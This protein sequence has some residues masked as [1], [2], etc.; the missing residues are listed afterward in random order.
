MAAALAVALALG[1][2]A[3]QAV[4]SAYAGGVP[5]RAANAGFQPSAPYYATFFYPWFGNKTTNGTW[6]NSTWGDNGHTPPANWFSNYLP[7][8]EPRVFDPAHEL[9]SS[10]DDTT[11]A[12]QLSKLAEAKQEVAISSWWGQGHKTDTALKH[13]LWY[14]QQPENPYPNLRWALYYEK[15]GFGNPSVDEIASDLRYIVDNLASQSAFF[16]IDGKPVIFV[17]GS[18][19]DSPATADRWAEARKQAGVD[20]FLVLK[21][22][23]GYASAKSQ[24]DGWH[25]YAPAER[26]DSQSHRYFMVSPGFWKDG[27]PARLPRDVD[28]FTRVVKNMVAA[29]V[30][31]KLTETWNEWGEGTAVE[32]GTPVIQTMTG[33]AIRDP[34]GPPFGN[35]YVDVLSRSLPPLEQGTGAPLGAS[36]PDSYGQTRVPDLVPPYDRPKRVGG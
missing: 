13:I 9:Y 33:H 20:I 27:E 18:A 10:I 36:S 5:E 26:A 4:P 25:Q 34:A 12:W 31:W 2:T 17:Y 3:A 19:E 28:A 35:T 16:R 14:M 24:P 22:F 7:D 1:P 15:E 23:H 30:P 21:V 32:P 8:L 11:L 29:D 6:A